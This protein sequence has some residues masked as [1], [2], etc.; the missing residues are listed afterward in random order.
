MLIDDIAAIVDRTIKELLGIALDNPSYSHRSVI[1]HP[2]AFD[3][4]Q[5]A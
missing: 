1:L 4:V 2:S 5:A 3:N